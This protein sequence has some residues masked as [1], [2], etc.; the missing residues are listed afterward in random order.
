MVKE[1]IIPIENKKP[2]ET[3]QE[4]KN[5]IPSLEEF[6]K[7]Y[8]SDEG[9][10]DSYNSEVD[11]YKDIRVGKISGPMP[12]GDETALMIVKSASIMSKLSR[13]YPTIA[14]LFEGN[15]SGTMNFLKANGAFSTFRA[16]HEFYVV[17]QVKE[18]ELKCEKIMEEKLTIMLKIFVEE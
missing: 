7:T 17:I 13:D 14:R 4:L 10:I 15:R 9:I 1:N 16:S 3:V 18:M 8:E 6:M 12:Y 11:S 5:E 2:F